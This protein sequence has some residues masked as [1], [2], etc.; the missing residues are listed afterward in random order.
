MNCRTYFVVAIVLVSVLGWTASYAV[1]EVNVPTPED[2]QQT[3][4]KDQE[5]LNV[6]NLI[7]G[8]TDGDF[9]W[10]LLVTLIFGA[11]GGIVYELLILQGNIEKWHKYTKEE[12]EEKFPYAIYKYMYDL[13]I[14]A[15]MIIGALAAVV[16]LWIIKPSTTF[17]WLAIAV[18]SG[19]AGTSVFRSMQDRLLA[20][21]AQKDVTDLKR[22]LQFQASKL[23]EL[24]QNLEAQPQ[25]PTPRAFEI[26]SEAKGVADLRGGRA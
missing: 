3:L 26:L 18:V 10:V 25:P 23:N 16:G 24:K 20:A 2:Q 19:S 8:M 11:V 21:I 6:T 5:P 1:Q 13:G 15:R 22:S 12:S 17:S 9:W 4:P 7:K 14:L